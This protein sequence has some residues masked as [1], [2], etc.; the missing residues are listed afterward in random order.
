MRVFLA[1][2]LLVSLS[3]P[4]YAYDEHATQY[5][6]SKEP[7]WKVGTRDTAL[8]LACRQGRFN[9]ARINYYYMTFTNA[10]FGGTTGIAKVGFN[11]IDK[12]NKGRP[13]ETY[14]FY[15]DGTSECGVFIAK[16]R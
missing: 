14:F 1:L 4:A 2:A 13:N 10:E 9:E 16:D 7:L 11:L 12:D 3:S 6:I 15:Q 5:G 8:S